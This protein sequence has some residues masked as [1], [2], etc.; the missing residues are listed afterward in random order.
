VG[1][2]L[3]L[4]QS[5]PARLLSLVCD[6]RRVDAMREPVDPGTLAERLEAA[7]RRLARFGFDLHDG[8]MQSVAA[9][10][11]DLHHFRDQLSGALE[12]HKDARRV[13][14]RVDEAIARVAGIDAELRELVSSAESSSVLGGTF[15]EAIEEVVDA[16][17]GAC[18]VT[19]DLDPELDDAVITDSQRIAVVRIVQAALA[20]VVRHSC[21]AT[22][23]VRVRRTADGIE[24]AVCDDGV[25]FVVEPTLERAAGDGRIGLV[26]M[27]ERVRLLGG[28]FEV[29]SKPGGPTRIRVYLPRWRPEPLT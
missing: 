21:A 9:L 4:L 17:G 7:Q 14:G 5:E 28:A 8:P 27:R 10:G 2:C 15:A 24:A 26:A 1:V 18:R 11:A 16:T 25:G 12:G 20:N 22:A 29:E 3:N 23:Q 19:L 13:V 6:T